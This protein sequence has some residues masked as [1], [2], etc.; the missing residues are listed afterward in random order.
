MPFDPQAAILA[1]RKPR[2]PREERASGPPI[3]VL[4][5]VVAA[6]PWLEELATIDP[7]RVRAVAGWPATEEQVHPGAECP[8]RTLATNLP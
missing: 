1:E 8:R 3:R 4:P 6:R 5:L 2:E 7:L